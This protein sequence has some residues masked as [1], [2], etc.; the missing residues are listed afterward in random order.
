MKIKEIIQ[1]LSKHDLESDFSVMHNGKKTHFEIVS[2]NGLMSI[3][4]GNTSVEYV[5]SPAPK[6][7]PGFDDIISDMSKS[8]A[9]KVNG[10]IEEHNKFRNSSLS[11]YAVDKI[12]KAVNEKESISSEDIAYLPDGY[13]FSRVDFDNFFEYLNVV[14]EQCYASEYSTFLERR[15]YFE[16]NGL[17]FIWRILSGQ[18]TSCQLLKAQETEAVWPEDWPMDFLED[19]KH[20]LK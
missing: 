3:R 11:D 12:L 8:L 7:D 15:R 1:E 13:D 19:K 16:Y 6:M 9:E 5:E 10:R 18:G 14:S 20:V 2:R 4:T 17:K